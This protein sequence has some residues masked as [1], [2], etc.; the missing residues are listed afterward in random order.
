MSTLNKWKIKNKKIKI[1]IPE[2]EARAPRSVFWT[3][4]I[5]S[6]HPPPRTHPRTHAHTQSLKSSNE[7]HYGK[8]WIN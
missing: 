7:E 8:N 4:P 6:P 5:S 2:G 1:K 3:Q